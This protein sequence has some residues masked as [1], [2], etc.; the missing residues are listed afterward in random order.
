MRPAAT[1]S[2]TAGSRS[3][4]ITSRPRSAKDSASGRPTRPRPTT[5]TFIAKR[6]ASNSAPLGQVLARER[7]HEARIRAQVAAQ[8]PARLLE[9]AVDPLESALLHPGR[10]HRYAAGVEVEGGAHAA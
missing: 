9:R 7:R 5:A 8:Q 10:R 2:S 6:L 3:T 4:P 1:C